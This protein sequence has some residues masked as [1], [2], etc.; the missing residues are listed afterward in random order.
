[1]NSSA[2]KEPYL[3]T[4][5]DYVRIFKRRKFWFLVPSLIILGCAV[6]LA[7]TLPAVYESR[8]TIL[9]EEQEIPSDFVR[10]TISSY[11]DQQVQVVAQRVLKTENVSDI[12]AKYD[13]YS[14]GDENAAGFGLAERFRSNV[15]LDLVSAEVVDQRS[16]RSIQA[17][18][19]FTLGFTDSNPDITRQVA[20]DLTML[21]LDENKR[22]RAE[23]AGNT[24][25]FLA[26][27]ASRIGDELAEIEGRLAE[28]KIANEGS[29]PEQYRFNLDAMERAEREYSELVFRRQELAKRKVE[30]SSQLAQL[31]P[32]APVVL[33]TGELV[34]S[35]ADRLRA[36]QTEHRGKAAIYKSNHPDLI[37]LEREIALLQGEL[38]LAVD[39]DDLRRQLREQE[40]YLADL[41]SKYNDNHHEVQST[42][43]VIEQLSSGLQEA[44][45]T[46]AGAGEIADNP[47]YVLLQTQLATL[48]TEERSQDERLSQLE[49][50]IVRYQEI[51]RRTPSVEQEYQ[52]LL[53]DYDNTNAEYQRIKSNQRDAETSRNLE[54]EQK[55]ERFVLLQSPLRPYE[56]VSPNRPV[57]IFLGVILAFGAGLGS[58]LGREYMD[59]SIKGMRELSNI[60]GEGPLVAVPYIE[61]QKDVADNR[62]SWVASMAIVVCVLGAFSVIQSL[63]VAS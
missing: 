33:A 10:S 26:K 38:G 16:G 6:I 56:P 19:A 51:L 57:I 40:Q 27:E 34:M 58:V 43:R 53:R 54:Q 45:L 31:S 12:V 48:E 21:F 20:E 44:K 37:R 50:K 15:K 55:G 1:M 8:S 35:D 41:Q 9:I 29:L 49:E 2:L 30:L 61:N 28:F 3:W 39:T 52:A 32:S 36:L 59:G 13:L 23:R 42:R 24:E 5:Q 60:M 11:A 17:T 63:A 25:K 47:A 4:W 7:V 46:S 14:Q 22:N 62:L 18:I